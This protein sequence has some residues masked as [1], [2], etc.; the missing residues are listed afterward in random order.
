MQ[1]KERVKLFLV[2]FPH[3]K[4]PGSTKGY[5]Q[6][7]PSSLAGPM[8]LLA[9]MRAILFAVRAKVWFFACHCSRQIGRTPFQH[10]GRTAVE[11][12]APDSLLVWS[13]SAIMASSA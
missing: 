8:L 10:R 1:L 5:L 4:R 3:F 12:S 9:T 6:L 7:V 11:L 13:T 2:F